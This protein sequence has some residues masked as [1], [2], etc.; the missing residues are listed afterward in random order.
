MSKL[1]FPPKFWVLA[2]L[3][4]EKGNPGLTQ[5]FSKLKKDITKLISVH[6]SIFIFLSY[7][8][9]IFHIGSG[10]AAQQSFFVKHFKTVSIQVLS[11]YTS[12]AD[13][14][15]VALLWKSPAMISCSTNNAYLDIYQ[16][17]MFYKKLLLCSHPWPNMNELCTKLK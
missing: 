1:F 3:S 9:L 5:N 10:M 13:A 6:D 7:G 16:F 14:P 4:C 8:T 15:I 11:L 12:S 17:D 2:R